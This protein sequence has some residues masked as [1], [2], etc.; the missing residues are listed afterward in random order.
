MRALI[1]VFVVLL[2]A[3]TSGKERLVEFITGMKRE[4][5]AVTH[6]SPLPEVLPP[7]GFVCF[8]RHFAPGCEVNG[9]DC[10]PQSG[11]DLCKKEKKSLL[12]LFSL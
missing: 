7:E 8:M 9:V 1:R 5:R 10:S 11:S 2:S 6:P 3:C 4:F 12:M